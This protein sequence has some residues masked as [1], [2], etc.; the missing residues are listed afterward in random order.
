MRP[1][2]LNGKNIEVILKMNIN[3]ENSVLL[4]NLKLI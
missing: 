4:L 2:E 3:P 1:G